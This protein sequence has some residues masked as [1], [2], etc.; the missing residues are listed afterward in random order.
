[1]KLAALAALVITL[2]GCTRTVD[3]QPVTEPPPQVDC[4]L[5][6]PAPSPNA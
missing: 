4:N 1:M 3:A 6:F 5:I 2:A